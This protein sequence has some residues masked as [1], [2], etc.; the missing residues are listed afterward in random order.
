MRKG[1]RSR[2]STV[3]YEP[4]E[5]LL[6]VGPQESPEGSNGQASHPQDLHRLPTAPPP[7]VPAHENQAPP[8]ELSLPNQQLRIQLAELHAE[9]VEAKHRCSEEVQVSVSFQEQLRLA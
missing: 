6:A 7:R 1:S 2:T 4:S 9:L 5:K 8:S 3:L